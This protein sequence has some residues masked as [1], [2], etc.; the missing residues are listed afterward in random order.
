MSQRNVKRAQ[1]MREK[2]IVEGIRDHQR[3]LEELRVQE[4]QARRRGDLGKAAEIH[5]GSLPA[6]EKELENLRAELTRVQT[7][8]GYLKEEVTD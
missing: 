1:W 4:E 7:H 6:A 5:Y 2:E 8:G 3:Q